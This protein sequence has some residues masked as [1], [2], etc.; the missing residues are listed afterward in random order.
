M[1]LTTS[2]AGRVARLC[3]QREVR[4]H[5]R[6]FGPACATGSAPACRGTLNLLKHSN[7]VVSF[8][9]FPFARSC[10]AGP[11]SCR[12]DRGSVSFPRAAG[13]KPTQAPC[14]RSTTLLR[15]NKTPRR[16]LDPKRHQTKL[17][18]GPGAVTLRGMARAAGLVLSAA[19]R[20]LVPAALP[21]LPHAGERAPCPQR[22][23]PP[24]GRRPLYLARQRYVQ[25]STAL[26]ISTVHVQSAGHGHC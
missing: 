10:T 8:V 20:R 22:V 15:P 2:W 9:Q 25:T 3:E 5:G 13:Y 4:D 16:Q 11:A 12:S 26:H 24:P 7:Q 23:R 21:C 17:P 14:T 18:L 6:Q 19:A 1:P